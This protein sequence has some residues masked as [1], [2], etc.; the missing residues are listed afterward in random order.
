MVEIL[1]ETVFTYKPSSSY[2][3]TQKAS[4]SDFL[5][6]ASSTHHFILTPK[7][8]PS[9]YHQCKYLYI[10]KNKQKPGILMPLNLYQVLSKP[11]ELLICNDFAKKTEKDANLVSS[12]ENKTCHF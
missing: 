11:G 5:T 4:E 2:C 1:A 6:K 10:V 7:I 8:I 9:L 12:Y 3:A